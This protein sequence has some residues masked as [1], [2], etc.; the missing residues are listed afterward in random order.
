[1]KTLARNNAMK[2]KT[3]LKHLP[4]FKCG[5]KR[6]NWSRFIGVVMD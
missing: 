6:A 1:M 2:L 5:T 4:N 3:V